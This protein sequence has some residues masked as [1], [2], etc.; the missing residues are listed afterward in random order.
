MWSP[1][2]SV[3]ILPV[4]TLPRDVSRLR[5]NTQHAIAL[6]NSGASFLRLDPKRPGLACVLLLAAC[7]LGRFR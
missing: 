1:K 4:A 3:A 6:P 5:L 7:P 2:S